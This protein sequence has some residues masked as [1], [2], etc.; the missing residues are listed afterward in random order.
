MAPTLTFPL[1]HAVLHTFE[2]WSLEKEIGSVFCAATS[3]S[4]NPTVFFVCLFVFLL[5]LVASLQR[6]SFHFFS[7][8]ITSY[9]D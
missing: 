4:W 7:L 8:W 1:S 5:M 3:V 9:E 6:K 2:E